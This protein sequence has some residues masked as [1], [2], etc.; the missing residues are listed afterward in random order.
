MNSLLVKPKPSSEESTSQFN[1]N[2]I[3]NRFN[4]I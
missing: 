4:L 2:L 1:K 3:T